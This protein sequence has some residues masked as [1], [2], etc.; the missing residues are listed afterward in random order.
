MGFSCPGKQQL[1]VSCAEYVYTGHTWIN[2]IQSNLT[3]G[4]LSGL[5]NKISIWNLDIM[6]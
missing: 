1:K 4:K 6:T 5:V 3:L 2:F